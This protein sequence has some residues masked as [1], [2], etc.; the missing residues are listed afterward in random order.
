LAAA[1]IGGSL[2]PEAWARMQ[3]A[4]IRAPARKDKQLLE[5]L[6][7]MRLFNKAHPE[8]I[9]IAKAD[10]PVLN[11]SVR[12]LLRLQQAVGYG[13]YHLLDVDEAFQIGRNDPKVGEFPIAEVEF[14]EMIFYADAA[15]Y[16]FL[17]PKSLRKMTDRIPTL[18]VV[19][20]PGSGNY[21]YK[22]VPLATYEKI[23]RDVGERAVLTSG[24]RGVMKQFL[25]F[26]R[27]AY[28]NDGNLSLASRSFAPPGFSFH[29]I[30]DFDLGQLN[31]GPDN[32][33]ERFTNTDVFRRLRDLEYVDLRYPKDNLVGVRFEPWHIKIKGMG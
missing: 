10:L 32:F 27:K 25:L 8:D 1:V 14:L 17:G 30:S 33:T 26:L 21:L 22:G 13:R 5:Y 19:K 4:A 3:V 7:K 2:S 31:F 12:R 28:E 15:R 18:E 29:G 11:A 20:I 24:V 23:R 9:F 16:G 6:E